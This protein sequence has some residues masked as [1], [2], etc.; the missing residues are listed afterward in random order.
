[1]NNQG[2]DHYEAALLLLKQLQVEYQNAREELQ[3]VSSRFNVYEVMTNRKL[4]QAMKQFDSGGRKFIS[5]NFHQAQL[6]QALPP[7][8]A[9]VKGRQSGQ[10]IQVYCLGP[11]RVRVNQKTIETW[12]STKAKS[13]FIYLITQQGKPVSKDILMELFWP[14]FAPSLANNSLK[15]AVR[16]LRQTFSSAYVGGSDCI[17]IKYQNG[18]YMVNTDVNIWLD[19]VQFEYHWNTGKQLEK[20]QKLDEAINEYKAAES[21]YCGDYL[22]ENLYEDWTS[23]RREALKDI[24]LTILNK[25]ATYSMEKDNYYDCITNCQKILTKDPCRED[26]YRHI[27]RCYSRL[28]Q[29]NRAISWYNLC[30]NVI[31]KELKMPP[32][33]HTIVLYNAL[34]NGKS[35]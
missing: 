11:F 12:K 30:K 13:L 7:E 3:E 27:M 17:W 20:D 33:Q 34:L 6:K 35:I 22:E 29:R 28:G 18:H 16:L 10:L 4:L 23:L 1:V 19:V 5:T 8:D 14:G 2:I 31:M 15:T 24:Y 9:S 21:L 25:L 32:D 26:A